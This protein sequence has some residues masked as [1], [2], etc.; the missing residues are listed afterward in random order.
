MIA[1]LRVSIQ[2][3]VYASFF[4]GGYVVGQIALAIPGT[5]RAVGVVADR[6]IAMGAA[7]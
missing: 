5:D 3:A 4:V 2:G 7:A 6:L 1:A